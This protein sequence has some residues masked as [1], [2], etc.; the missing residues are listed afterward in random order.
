MYFLLLVVR[1]NVKIVTFAWFNLSQL[2]DTLNV[3]L[4]HGL[5]GIAANCVQAMQKSLHCIKRRDKSRF[6]RGVAAVVAKGAEHYT[7]TYNVH[8][9]SGC[10]GKAKC[11]S[12]I[13]EITRSRIKLHLPQTVLNSQHMGCCE[14]R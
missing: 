8:V 11:V 12:D 4:C 2:L 6:E 9:R 10:I 13:R 14:A 5:W 1:N 3:Y 7:Y